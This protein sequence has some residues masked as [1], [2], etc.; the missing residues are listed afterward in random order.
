M[1]NRVYFI[2]KSQKQNVPKSETTDSLFG[3]PKGKK[4]LWPPTVFNDDGELEGFPMSSEKKIVSDLPT[5]A[6]N[7]PSE[8]FSEQ[9][10][11]DIDIFKID[12]EVPVFIY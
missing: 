2:N 4:D 9:E 10:E 11:V 7:S 1:A 3:D 12:N 5:Y 6:V 8:S